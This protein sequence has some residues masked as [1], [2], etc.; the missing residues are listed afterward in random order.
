MTTFN[1][2]IALHSKSELRGWNEVLRE[3]ADWAGWNPAD[4]SM[5]DHLLQTGD[6]VATIGWSMYQ[7]IN[8]VT[9]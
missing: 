9:A 3:R 8:E 7:V 1:P 2:L 4:K 6:Y 5:I